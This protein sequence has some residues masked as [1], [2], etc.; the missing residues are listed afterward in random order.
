MQQIEN[1]GVIKL[2]AIAGNDGAFEAGYTDLPIAEDEPAAQTEARLDGGRQGMLQ[3][4]KGALIREGRIRLHDKY[5]GRDVE[6][7]VPEQG[8]VV[9]ARFYAVGR[10]F[11]LI[12]VTGPRPFVTS[13]EANRFLDSLALTGR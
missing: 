4:L 5:P 9:R 6:A 8:W 12:V 2:Y 1:G 7:N 10:R 11:Y 3:R 13:P